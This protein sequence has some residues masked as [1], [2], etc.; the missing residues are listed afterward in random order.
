M[1][2]L[3]RLF[4][5][6]PAA[7]PAAS[8][9][10]AA[11]TPVPPAAPAAPAA[12]PADDTQPQGPQGFVLWLLGLHDSA[13]EALLP[14]ERA[15]LA[16]LDDVLAEPR[17]PAGLLPR[18]A[19][20]VPQLIAMLRQDN[21][22]VSALAE[23]V[24]KDP[25]VAA[26]VLRLASSAY[27]QTQGAA[28]TDLSQAIQRLGIAGLQTAIARVLLRPLYSA[29]PGTL[30]ARAAGRLWAHA[31]VLARHTAQAA[32]QAGL[33]MFD[34]YLTGLLLNTGWTVLFLV[35]DRGGHALDP[36]PTREAAEQLERRAFHLF[37]LAASQ[38]EITPAF[39][40]FAAAARKTPLA[41]HPH[42]LAKVLRSVQVAA[43]VEAQSEDH[44]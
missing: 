27:Y 30:S 17:L 19:S 9:R 36:A 1:S 12:V 13:G 21:L 37:G 8:G 34:G 5:R 40:D 38:W 43:L 16:S 24:S 35:L 23:R 18:A 29:P 3:S 14:A 26:E 31:D 10:T 7:A 44:W 39:A 22:P 25:A 6:Q 15:A 41:G 2:W 28:I 20:V 11:G 4:G 42:P 33:S 32:Q